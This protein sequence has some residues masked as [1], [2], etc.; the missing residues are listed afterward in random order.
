MSRVAAPALISVVLSAVMWVGS[1]AVSELATAPLLQSVRSVQK[2]TA[3][4]PVASE[5]GDRSTV[6]FAPVTAEGLGKV[7]ET[8]NFKVSVSNGR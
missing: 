7:S 1:G 3:T 8:I 5:Y 4:M 6:S 2:Q